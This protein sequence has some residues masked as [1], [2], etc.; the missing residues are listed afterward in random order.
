MTVGGEKRAEQAAEQSQTE[1]VTTTNAATAESEQ[2]ADQPVIFTNTQQ[3]QNALSMSIAWDGI[4][5]FF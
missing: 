5:L 1:T 2:S 3:Q 4:F